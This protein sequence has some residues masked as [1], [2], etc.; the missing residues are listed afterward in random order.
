M[1]QKVKVLHTYNKH[2]SVFVK[3]EDGTDKKTVKIDYD[4]YFAIDIKD[5]DRALEY[6]KT[7]NYYYK[8]QTDPAFPEY[9]KIYTKDIYKNRQPVQ[10][11]T[12]VVLFL[13]E[14]G[15]ST[16]EG[17]LLADK[18]WYID[19]EIEIGSNFSKLYFDIETDD[20]ID[21]IE[22]GRDRILSFAAI[23]NT[24]KIYFEV[25][26]ELTDEAE[27]K[28][29][30]KVLNII[31]KYDILLGWNSS[32]FDIPYLKI[33]MKKYGLAENDKYIWKELANF[34]LL[35]RFR[36][37]F[38][39]DSHIK[40]FALNFI[41][42]HFLGRGKVSRN[43]KVI[44]LYKKNKE[45]LK[46]YNIEDSILVKDLDDKLGVSNMM[47]RQCQ[48]CGVPPSQFG[49]YSIIDAY[50]LKKAH[51]VGQFCQTSIKAIQERSIDHSR[52]RENPSDT[53]TEKTKY[54]GAI[55]LEPKIG[56]Y[57]KVYTFDFKGLY[58]SMMRTSN[59]GYD[60]LR[61]EP[62]V[63][64]IINPGTFSLLRKTGDIKPTFFEKEPSIINLAIS[65]L[66]I[67]RTEY[68]NLKLKMIEDGTNSGPEWEKVVSDEIIVKE[69]A[70][71]TYGI[72][73]LEYGRYFSVD[74]A[75]SITLFGQYM[76]NFAKSFFEKEGFNVIY[77][78]TDSVFV[79]TLKKDLDIDGYLKKFHIELEIEL[80]EK[81][82]IDKSYIQLNFDKQYESFILIAKKTYVGH[83]IN[84]EGKKT[85]EVYARGLEYHKKNTFSYAA[86]KQKQLIDYILSENPD[87]KNL[88]DWSSKTRN[89]FF[90]QEFSKED[91][92]LTQKVGKKLEDYAKT[93]PLH[94]RLA[95]E[96]SNKTG[97]VFTNSEI[98]YII[99]SHSD[100][101]DGVI[102]D[103][104]TGRYCKD[105]YWEN[106]TVPVLERVL[107][108]IHPTEL[109][110][111]N[112]LQL[113]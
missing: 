42:N 105:Y 20:T 79:S 58:P 82:N 98:D 112:N 93:A 25:L 97:Q 43:E 56:K 12:D 15:I 6:L 74:V 86:K 91:L 51:T 35:K 100:K 69:L 80:K 104:Y 95:K 70:N 106:K 84:I 23:D 57:D 17:D 90:N 33:R 16:Y 87:L 30:R 59:I 41:A 9:L 13:E 14:I 76:I 66:I 24:G 72:M 75:E 102:A 46:E 73:G 28:M 34:D 50:I 52:V 7:T 101:I 77:G 3:Y 83:V 109:F 29:L 22:V 92:I 32:Q 48:W 103:E 47:I 5:K 96:I 54:T 61:Y 81:Y 65:D 18:K 44:D 49:L 85:N 1:K 36:H 27:T 10:K 94:V 62:G 107:L 111:P 99:T 40:T 108:A 26:D 60:T 67:K 19:K 8:V 45:K 71:S 78:D 113:F 63:N 21:K 88:K 110:F 38:R 55:V 64:R 39:F 11:K 4:W 2:D 53:T 68:K 37:I 89:D 31:Q